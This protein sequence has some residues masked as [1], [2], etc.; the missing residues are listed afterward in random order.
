MAR[1]V[2]AQQ[3]SHGEAPHGSLLNAE[4]HV[5]FRTQVA[6]SRIGGGAVRMSDV[7]ALMWMW[8]WR[9]LGCRKAWKDTVPRMN[10]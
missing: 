10:Q 2:A 9:F 6:G 4:L 1:W 7:V 8:W 3:G 5:G